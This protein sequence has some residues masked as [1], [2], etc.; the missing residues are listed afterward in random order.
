MDRFFNKAIIDVRF[1]YQAA[2]DKKLN[3]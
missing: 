1:V 3:N 2:S